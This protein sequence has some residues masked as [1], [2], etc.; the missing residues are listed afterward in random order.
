M[1]DTQILEY[2]LR[3]FRDGNWNDRSNQLSFDSMPVGQD[4]DELPYHW[5]GDHGKYLLAKV[6]RWRE[7]EDREQEINER[8]KKEVARQLK[9]QK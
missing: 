3:L 5:D 1:N 8:I 2:V 7:E 4:R 9:A 6:R